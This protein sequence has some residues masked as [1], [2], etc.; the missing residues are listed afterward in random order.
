MMHTHM[1][2]CTHACITCAHACFPDP[3]T[4][5]GLFTCLPARSVCG[6]TGR[7]GGGAGGARTHCRSQRAP[8][9]P[10]RCACLFGLR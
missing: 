7:A 3:P 9:H 4:N 8:Q 6:S 1:H 10:I 2:A 5:P